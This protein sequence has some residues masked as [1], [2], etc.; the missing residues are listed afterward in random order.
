M[1]SQGVVRLERV[2]FDK[3]HQEATGE[4]DKDKNKKRKQNKQDSH[5]ATAHEATENNQE[6]ATEHKTTQKPP[7]CEQTVATLL[8]SQGFTKEP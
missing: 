4:Q 1:D 5:T 8:R 2:E 6:T 7:R 3:T